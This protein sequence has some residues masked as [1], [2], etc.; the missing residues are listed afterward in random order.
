MQFSNSYM[1]HR[2]YRVD[3]GKAAAKVGVGEADNK[4]GERIWSNAV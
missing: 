3:G 1:F 2:L 4:Q